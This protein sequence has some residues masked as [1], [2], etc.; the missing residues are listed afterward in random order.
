MRV[1]LHLGESMYFFSECAETPEQQLLSNAFKDIL[2]KCGIWVQPNAMAILESLKK[3]R[4]VEKEDEPVQKG[5]LAQ[6]MEQK[7]GIK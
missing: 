5:R 4:I 3:V 7:Y 2:V 1:L 6:L